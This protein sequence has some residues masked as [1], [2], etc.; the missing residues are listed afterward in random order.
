MHD[1]LHHLVESVQRSLDKAES[2]S[3]EKRKVKRII[4]MWNA[5]F[6]HQ[7]GR[8]ATQEERKQQAKAH[9]VEHQRLSKLLEARNAKVDEMLAR[10][11]VTRDEFRELQAAL[12]Q[13][14]NPSISPPGDC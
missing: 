1:E 2:L 10:M 6:E 8:T 9:Y 5:T 13:Q 14:P 3:H 11:G 4:K 7:H 12:E